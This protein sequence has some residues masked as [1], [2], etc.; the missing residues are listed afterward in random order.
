MKKSNL[1][2]ISLLLVLTVCI[3][4]FAGCE[5]SELREY[6]SEMPSLEPSE[7]SPP[8][9]EEPTKDFTPAYESYAPDTVML[10]VNGHD[11]TWAELFYWYYSDIYYLESYF[12]EI[13]DWDALIFEDDTVTFREYIVDYAY[14]LTT[15]YRAIETMAEELDVTISDE[16]RASIDEAWESNLASYQSVYGG[17]EADFIEELKKDF[18][19]KETF[20]YV[21]EINALAEALRESLY[22]LEGENIPE[23]EAV[24]KAEELGYMRAKHVLIMTVDESN[25]PLA[26]DVKAEKLAQAQ[27]ILAELQAVSSDPAALEAKMDELMST[28]SEDTGAAYYADGYTFVPGDMVEAFE[29][30]VKSMENYGLSEI[31]ETNYGYHIIIRLPLDMQQLPMQSA[32]SLALK[33]SQAMFN[34]EAQIRVDEAV[35]VKSSEYESMDIAEVFKKVVIKE[36]PAE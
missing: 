3:G 18:M 24:A 15:R 25:Q 13:T 33:V 21:Y 12:G 19:S 8:A 31:V 14:E 2:K 10:T 9:A 20:Y 5:N 28:V 1:T 17:D 22:G 30:A 11:V 32:D 23:E 35:I 36:A 29:E 6:S 4:V 7:S 34:D 27:G 26:D 16:A